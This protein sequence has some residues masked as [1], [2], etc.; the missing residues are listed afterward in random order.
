MINLEEA[1]LRKL[2]TAQHVLCTVESCTGGLVAHSITNVSGASEIFWGSYVTYDNSAKLELGVS[3][4]TLEKYG[5][6]SKE[7][8]QELAECGLKK[9]AENPDR[10]NSTN[11]I[12]PKGWV[13]ISTT[14]IAGPTG[15]TLKKPVGLCFIA[16]AMTGKKTR[17]EEF[18]SV[19]QDRLLIKEQ[20]AMK[21]LEILR[22]LF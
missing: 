8:A 3:L 21:A 13:C 11:L 6:V 19:A 5:A 18:H 10:S 12:K 1:V 14:G 7:V 16:V 22:G 4:K 9:F 20:F 17:V 2:K 15:G